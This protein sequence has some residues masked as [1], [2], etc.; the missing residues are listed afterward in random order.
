MVDCL[1]PNPEAKVLLMVLVIVTRSWLGL[2]PTATDTVELPEL[3]YPF[4]VA[5]AMATVVALPRL[6]GRLLDAVDLDVHPRDV[7]A[8]RSQ[9]EEETRGDDGGEDRGVPVLGATTATGDQPTERSSHEWVPG[10]QVA[11]GRGSN[12]K[13]AWSSMLTS[14]MTNPVRV[15]WV[16]VM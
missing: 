5:T 3:G 11:V 7:D 16:A 8:G 15:L 4:W 13:T 10:A 9:G 14:W 1:T 6:F 12:W 2:S